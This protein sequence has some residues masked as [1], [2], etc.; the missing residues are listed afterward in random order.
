[1]IVESHFDNR[2]IDDGMRP[3]PSVEMPIVLLGV[4]YSGAKD[5]AVLVADD[6]GIGALDVTRYVA[7]QLRDT[8]PFRR[9]HALQKQVFLNVIY[10]ESLGNKLVVT[11]DDF[12]ALDGF[13]ALASRQLPA[14]RRPRLRGQRY[15]GTAVFLELDD[16][17]IEYAAKR[18]SANDPGRTAAA[19][20]ER[21]RRGQGVLRKMAAKFSRLPDCPTIKIDAAKVD[22]GK[23][24]VDSMFD[25][26]CASAREI[27]TKLRSRH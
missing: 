2:P 16:S 4:Y 13:D 21:L 14:G 15:P 19:E 7:Y 11:V 6:L 25:T 23:D 18:I 17:M 22:M 10:D 3:P 26:Y 20:E 9:E 8:E 5:V 24:D 27:V 1:M 12:K